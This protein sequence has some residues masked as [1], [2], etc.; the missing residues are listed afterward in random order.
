MSD[1]GKRSSYYGFSRKFYEH[2][3]DFLTD[4]A[5]AIAEY[6]NVPITEILPGRADDAHRS[7]TTGSLCFVGR[8][9]LKLEADVDARVMFKYHL[10]GNE[11]WWVNIRGPRG[12]MF[13]PLFDEYFKENT[14][15]VAR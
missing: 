11:E 3:V 1:A 7:P 12:K 10:D 13:Y 6:F 14:N 9:V 4:D 15:K 5:K 8:V 2:Y